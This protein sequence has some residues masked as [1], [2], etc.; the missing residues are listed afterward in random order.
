MPKS[1]SMIIPAYREGKKP[2]ELLK[3]VEESKLNYYDLE[4]IYL[5]IQGDI[6]PVKKFSKETDL[7]LKIIEEKERRGKASAINTGLREIQ[8]KRIVL[9]SADILL[10]DKT[11]KK[12]L[13]R[14]EEEKIGIVTARPVPLNNKDSFA[15]YF[16]NTLWRLHH[17]VSKRQPKAGE[18]IAFKNVIDRLPENTAADEEFIKSKMLMKGYRAKYEEEAVVYNEGPYNVSNLFN[19]RWRI[20]IGHLDLKK[21]KN[22]SA[23]SMK[24]S[25]ILQS[26]FEY[27]Q[28]EGIH[29]YFFVSALFELFTRTSAWL[30]YKFFD[31]NPYIWNKS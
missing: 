1:F 24:P 7:P 15:G 4:E 12:L 6:G 2:V 11:L 23:P 30:S 20:F 29:P 8:N 28:K 27:L 26:V 3:T 10:E 19:Q 14:L 5:V 22:Y 16:I 21:R 31:K 9:S 18:I 13:E 25:I 17:L